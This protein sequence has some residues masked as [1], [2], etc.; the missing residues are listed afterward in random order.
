M[1]PDKTKDN[2]TKPHIRAFYTI[3]KEMDRAYNKQTY[4]QTD[5]EPNTIDNGGTDFQQHESKVGIFETKTEVE[6][7]LA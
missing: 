3:R 5:T 4:W 2:K 6:W 1:S 7:K